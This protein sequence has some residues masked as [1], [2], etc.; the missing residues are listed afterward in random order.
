MYFNQTY[1]N[2]TVPYVV[3]P[4]ANSKSEAIALLKAEER[5]FEALPGLKCRL[6]LPLS[7]ILVQMHSALSI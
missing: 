6:S 2:Q 5:R 3:F 4:L 1:F 7:K